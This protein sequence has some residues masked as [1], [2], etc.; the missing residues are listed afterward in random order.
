MS[1]LSPDKGTASLGTNPP[2]TPG[3]VAAGTTGLS[4]ICA[5]DH[6]NLTATGGN[7]SYTWSP[8]VGLSATG[9]AV[10]VAG[11]LVTTTYTVTSTNPNTGAPTT[12]SVTVTVSENCCP[13]NYNVGY[14]VDVPLSLYDVSTGSPFAGYPA[15][16]RFHLS[17]KSP[18][19]F[20]G[21]AVQP[22]M[23]SVLLMDANKDIYLQ[24]GASL[25]L[26]GVSITA[27]CHDMWGKLWVRNTAAGITATY[28]NGT[29]GDPTNPPPAGLPTLRNQLSHSLGGMDFEQAAASN[30]GPYYQVAGTDF[31]HNEQSMV[32]HR[33]NT[34]FSPNTS[35]GLSDFVVSSLFDSKPESFKT[36]KA[37]ATGSPDYPHYS[38]YHV[39][40][41]GNCVAE[42]NYSTFRNALFGFHSPDDGSRSFLDAGENRY[43]NLWLAAF[44]LNSSNTTGRLF[45]GGPSYFVFPTATTLPTTPQFTAAIANDVLDGVGETR[46][47]YTNASMLVTVYGADFRQNSNPYTDYSFSQRYKQVGIKAKRAGTL[48]DNQFTLLH[49]GIEFSNVLFPAANPYNL[50]G[51]VTTSTFTRCQKGI[52]V[53]GIGTNRPSEANCCPS[54]TP[55]VYLPLYCNTFDR[56]NGTF[57]GTA[58]GIVVGGTGFYSGGTSVILDPLPATPATTFEPHSNKF[59]DYSTGT[60]GYYAIFNGSCV[61]QADFKYTTFPAYIDPAA[62][63]LSGHTQLYYL[64]NRVHLLGVGT[65]R[66]GQVC[67][68]GSPGLERISKGTKSLAQ[69]S[70]NPATE[71]TTFTYQ[72]T[73][74]THSAEL[75]VSRGTDGRQLQRYSLPLK[76]EGTYEL[77]LRGWQP[78]LYFITL[79]ADEVP[80]QT[81]RLLVH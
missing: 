42:W 30:T 27:A 28:A 22:P 65:Y 41:T 21:L 73:G 14:M 75:R 33:V 10:I 9:G 51:T 19:I 74:D 48:T 17:G 56:G 23:G 7:G 43:E 46:G 59:L 67:G 37:Y 54:C 35:N 40:F 11:P 72:L 24:D 16:T 18:I 77:K 44:N 63:L 38:R 49:T 78:G 52:D 55:T 76:R 64:T 36:P 25:N 4:Y 31:L 47:I 20:S 39:W 29:G 2:G 34:P 8:N 12:A 62:Q 3:A 5:G 69:S 32:M 80:I 68:F 53:S 79:Y 66:P 81:R 57:P 45:V 58:Y 1:S 61:S 71:S 15:G 70:P 6:I 26:A 60:A 50:L 13:T